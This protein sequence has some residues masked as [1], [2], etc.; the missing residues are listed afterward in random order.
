M[1]VAAFRKADEETKIMTA[2]IAGGSI[3]VQSP[4]LQM[5]SSAVLDA[6]GGSAVMALGPAGSG[7]GGGVGRIRLETSVTGALPGQ[8]QPS[9]AAPAEYVDQLWTSLAAGQCTP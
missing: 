3:L 5:Q 8:P 9:V 4:T 1:R 2:T 7:G 6:R